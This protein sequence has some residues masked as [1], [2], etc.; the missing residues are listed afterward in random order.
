MDKWIELC[1]SSFSSIFNLAAEI[2]WNLALLRARGMMS[3]M[4]SPC[5]ARLR[6]SNMSAGGSHIYI[7]VLVS[8]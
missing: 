7:L 3:G 2:Q 8:I 4:M 6:T 1:V 5:V